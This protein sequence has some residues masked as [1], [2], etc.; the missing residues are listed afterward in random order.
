MNIVLAQVQLHD[1]IRR[2]V[3]DSCCSWHQR[4]GY[5]RRLIDTVAGTSQSRRVMNGTCLHPRTRRDT[6]Y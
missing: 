5:A 3:D 4:K 1:E 2:V 6:I